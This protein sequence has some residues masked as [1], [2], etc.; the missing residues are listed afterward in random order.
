MKPDREFDDTMLIYA[1]MLIMALMIVS[2]LIASF[3]K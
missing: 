2:I 1:L 3:L